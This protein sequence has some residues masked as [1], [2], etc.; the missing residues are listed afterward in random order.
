MPCCSRPGSISVMKQAYCSAVM[1]RTRW[2]MAASCS[3]GVIPAGS[4]LVTPRSVRICKPPTRTMKNSSRFEPV[5]ARN[6]SRSSSGI[7]GS[8]ASSS[9]RWLNSSQLSS[10]L[11][12]L[13]RR[14]VAHV[15]LSCLAA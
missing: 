2:R 15:C 6:F 14:V 9:T 11:M 13:T 10:R 12:Y 8:H 7:V 4:G 3:A 1:R 5:M